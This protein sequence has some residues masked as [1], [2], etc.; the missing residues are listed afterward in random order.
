MR[1]IAQQTDPLSPMASSLVEKARPSDQ[2]QVDWTPKDLFESVY[3]EQKPKKSVA[4]V[5]NLFLLVFDSAQPPKV[6]LLKHLVYDPDHHRRLP[7]R[8][9]LSLPLKTIRMNW[10]EDVDEPLPDEA[11]VLATRQLSEVAV[12]TAGSYVP[13]HELVPLSIYCD[14]TTTGDDRW[15]NT[16]VVL[17]VNEEAPDPVKFERYTSAWYSED[18]LS[19]MESDC[20]LKEATRRWVLQGFAALD[21]VPEGLADRKA[22]A[23]KE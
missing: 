21:D 9:K 11:Q 3:H 4:S 2:V 20:F 18:E 15:I 8:Q 17:Q 23:E 6:M 13:E 16:F 22:R 12:E 1:L 14:P 10:G 7:S 5:V 19:L